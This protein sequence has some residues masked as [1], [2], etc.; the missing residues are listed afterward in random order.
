M[1]DVL[2]R[3]APGSLMRSVRIYKPGEYRICRR[4][5]ELYSVMI[6]SSGSWGRARIKDAENRN[7]WQ[8]P[9]TF[10]GSFVLQAGAFGALIVEM[11]CFSPYDAPNLTVNWREPS[12]DVM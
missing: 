10:T 9:S 6:V 4:D 2:T 8:Q 11:A 3:P 12:L 1:I 7:L 5:C